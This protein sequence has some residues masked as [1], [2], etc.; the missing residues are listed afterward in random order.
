VE[1]GKLTNPGPIGTRSYEIGDFI[2]IRNG[3]GQ[4]VAMAGERFRFP[5]Y[6]EISGVCTRPGFEGRGL[7]ASLVVMV[8]RRICGR[9]EVPYLH[10]R[11]DNARAVKLY[12]RLGFVQSRSFPMAILRK[13]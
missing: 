3:D 6:S 7:A 8:M 9:G 1:L 2:G 13:T 5:G 11:A 4:L 12:E 10:S